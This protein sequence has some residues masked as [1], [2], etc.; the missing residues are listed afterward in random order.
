MIA[1]IIMVA[2]IVFTLFLDLAHEGF[3]Q[4][5]C[6]HQIYELERDIE[7]ARQLLSSEEVGFQSEVFAI[8]RPATTTSSSTEDT[9]APVPDGTVRTASLRAAPPHVAAQTSN[10]EAPGL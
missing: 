7:L 10:G 5:S 4:R 3:A 2:A 1:R 6:N 8:F 9:S